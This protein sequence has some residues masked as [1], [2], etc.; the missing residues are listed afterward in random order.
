MW[1]APWAGVPDR[2]ERR[3]HADPPSPALLLTMDAMGQL[4]HTLLSCL[5]SMID[6]APSQSLHNLLCSGIVVTTMRQT[7]NTPWL[8][9]CRALLIWVL[10]FSTAADCHGFSGGPAARSMT[11][12]H[13]WVG[14]H[15]KAFVGAASTQDPLAWPAPG[16]PSTHKKEKSGQVRSSL[17][18]YCLG[19]S[20]G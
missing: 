8:R 5:P 19:P 15:F 4:P 12:P 7:T 17:P 14:F 2:T 13:L 18:H 20:H 6:C 10:L 9:Y 3:L 11:L 1:A 16:G